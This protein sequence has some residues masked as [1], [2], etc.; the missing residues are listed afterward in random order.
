MG[1]AINKLVE[2]EKSKDTS[3]HPVS[4][5]KQLTNLDPGF[6]YPDYI[7]KGCRTPLERRRAKDKWQ[8]L[9]PHLFPNRMS[10]HR[11]VAKFKALEEKGIP[12]ELQKDRSQ[13]LTSVTADS[14]TPTTYRTLLPAMYLR[15]VI[16]D[17]LG[18]SMTAICAG[19]FCIL[20]MVYCS[21]PTLVYWATLAGLGLHYMESYVTVFLAINRCLMLYKSRIADS[22]FKGKRML[23]WIFS[24]I[25]FSLTTLWLSPP[26]IYNS[27]NAG[28]FLN[29][30]LHYL[31][32]QDYV[33]GEW[34]VLFTLR[35]KMLRRHPGEVCFPGGMRELSDSNPIETALREANEEIGLKH[36]SV[37]VVGVLKP[38][39]SRHLILIYPVLCILREPNNIPEL[40]VSSEVDHIFWTPLAN[41]LSAENYKALQIEQHFRIHVF[42]L[43]RPVFGITALLAIIVAMAVY[44]QHPSFEFEIVELDEPQNMQQDSTPRRSLVNIFKAIGK[45]RPLIKPDIL[46]KKLFSK[47]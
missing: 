43:E 11:R 27:I 35:S 1:P 22:L 36:E 16:I 24:P 37:N 9:N 44:D 17:V 29:P 46:N 38:I 5:P 42:K 26:L 39:P 6:K 28:M 31:P 13:R 25:I 21:A 41:F 15:N 12:I 14:M 45:V 40:H 7:Y 19:W 18:L 34:F 47:L 2:E 10:I 8:K 20:G 4:G 23:V 3:D 30:H 33:E 32:D